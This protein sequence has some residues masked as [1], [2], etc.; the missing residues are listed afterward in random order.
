MARS[1]G[2]M[3][4]IREPALTIPMTRSTRANGLLLAACLAQATA[5][6]ASDAGRLAVTVVD[7]DSEPVE[8]VAVYAV[9][10][11]P[12][13]APPAGAVMNQID[14][15]F[16]PHILVV[17]TGAEIEF[18]NSDSVSHHVYSFSPA[19]RFEL[20]LYRD[21][22][23]PPLAFGTPGV[24]TLGCNIHDDMLGFILVV[25]TPY[26][27]LTDAHGSARFDDLPPGRYTVEAW[28]PRARDGD[29]PAPVD[30]SI[31]AT[32]T[33]LT[34]EFEKKLFPAHAQSGGS[35]SWTDY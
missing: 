1:A 23:Y 17:Q 33:T 8:Q 5:A 16:V 11:Q 4:G 7:R 19:K 21:R 14:R 32:P 29:L 35:L 30:V 31:G 12:A 2:P 20:A 10:A 22:V 6:G 24:V 26:F 3:I 15:A 34:L 18:P 27:A 28:T 9:P 25:D 13:A